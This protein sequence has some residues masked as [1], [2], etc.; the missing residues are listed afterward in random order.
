MQKYRQNTPKSLFE[1][2]YTINELSNMVY[3]ICRY[4]QILRYN[5][6]WITA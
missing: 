2:Q 1:E 6:E 4:S 3:N 5:S